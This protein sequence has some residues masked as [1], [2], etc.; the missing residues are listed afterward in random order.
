LRLDIRRL[1]RDDESRDRIRFFSDK[2]IFAHLVFHTVRSVNLEHDFVDAGFFIC[3]SYLIRLDG[4]CIFIGEIPLVI[5][6]RLIG[7]H[8]KVHR[9]APWRRD[10]NDEYFRSEDGIYFYLLFYLSHLSIIVSDDKFDFMF[11]YAI[12]LDFYFFI[13]VLCIDDFGLRSIR[14]RSFICEIIVSI[15]LIDIRAHGSVQDEFR[16]ILSSVAWRDGELRD[17]IRGFS[18]DGKRIRVYLTKLVFNSQ[19]DGVDARF[20]ELLFD[21]FSL[22]RICL[23]SVFVK[24]L[25]R[26]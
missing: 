1:V 26:K 24:N 5:D 23:I 11:S 10:R 7:F 8:H 14:K 9:I 3:M 15:G 12:E 16:W 4:S 2:H 13:I 20:L 25:P 18:I 21:G 17:R 6:D 19:F 22:E